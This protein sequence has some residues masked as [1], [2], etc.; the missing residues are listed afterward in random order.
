MSF[1]NI[2]DFTIFFFSSIFPSLSFCFFFG[3]SVD[4]MRQYDSHKN[5]HSYRSSVPEGTNYNPLYGRG[6]SVTDNLIWRSSLIYFCSSHYWAGTFHLQATI[7]QLQQLLKETNIW[8][9]F[10]QFNGSNTKYSSSFCYLLQT[11]LF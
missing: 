6:Q 5:C 4:I 11:H 10:M 9:V 1:K 7:Q 3:C 8:I 2:L